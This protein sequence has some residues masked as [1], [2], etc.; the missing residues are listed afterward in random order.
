MYRAIWDDIVL[1]ESEH[2][3]RV[4]GN[5]YFPPEALNSEYFTTSPTTSQCPWKGSA[6]YYSITVNGTV[7]HDAA[8]YYPRP[9]PAA[10]NIRGH[11]AFWKGVR[12]IEIRDTD[13][14]PE[15]GRPTWWRKLTGRR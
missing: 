4:E 2:T 14:S 11:V 15:S 1:A 13:G 3:V 8:W 12:V 5:H 10:E 9:A 7:N 6:S